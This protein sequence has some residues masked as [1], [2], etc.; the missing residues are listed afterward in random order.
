VSSI[1]AITTTTIAIPISRL[2]EERSSALMYSQP[3]TT[4]TTV[5]AKSSRRASI[6]VPVRD[7]MRPAHDAFGRALRMPT[8]SVKKAH[9]VDTAIAAATS[10]WNSAVAPYRCPISASTAIITPSVENQCAISRMRRVWP[11]SRK[12]AAP[13]SAKVT[14]VLV[15]IRPIG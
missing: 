1:T 11:S 14:A 2:T 15:A 3:S 8:E 10:I 7:T 13:T 4:G 12:S 9:A 5:S 6:P